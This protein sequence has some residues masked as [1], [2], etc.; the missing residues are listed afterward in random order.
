[1]K[2][3]QTCSGF[4]MTR[5]PGGRQGGWGCTACTRLAH[6]KGG[7]GPGGGGRGFGPFGPGFGGFGLAWARTLTPPPECTTGPSSIEWQSSSGMPSSSTRLSLLSS[8]SVRHGE[9]NMNLKPLPSVPLAVGRRGATADCVRPRAGRVRHTGAG[10]VLPR[11]AA[12]T[13]S[14][15]TSDGQALQLVPRTITVRGVRCRSC[16]FSF[17]SVRVQSLTMVRVMRCPPLPL[18]AHTTHVCVWP[19][20]WNAECAMTPSQSTSAPCAR[21]GTAP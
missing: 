16:T 19:C 5:W 7:R 1:L 14:D 15:T 10:Q 21:C 11:L 2:E 8:C 12:M 13:E 6:K 18:P 4:Y 3:V 17:S 20:R 9:G